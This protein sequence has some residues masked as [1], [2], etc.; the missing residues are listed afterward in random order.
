MRAT[1]STAAC[2]YA[3][4]TG[5]ASTVH[6][7]HVP[8]VRPRWIW[9]RRELVRLAVPEGLLAEVEQ[10]GA[11]QLCVGGSGRCGASRD[12]GGRNEFVQPEQSLVHARTRHATDAVDEGV[13][14]GR[15]GRDCRGRRFEGRDRRRELG[16][17]LPVRGQRD[18]RV[19]LRPSGEHERIVGLVRRP[20]R[21]AVL[22][23]PGQ[24]AAVDRVRDRVVGQRCREQR[25]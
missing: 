23:E 16:D 6:S 1:P 20:T 19:R 3:N 13:D 7:Q 2:R 15:L 17:V 25:L 8:N 18:R 5:S 24:H 11:Q 10:P 12:T 21:G 4:D 22:V 9:S 14:H